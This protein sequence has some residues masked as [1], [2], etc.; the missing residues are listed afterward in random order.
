VRE[1]LGPGLGS[2]RETGEWRKS[3]LSRSIEAASQKTA[4]EWDRRLAATAMALTEHPGRRLAAAE[5]ALHRIAQFCEDQHQAHARNVEPQS[6]QVDRAHELLQNA[7]EACLA[8]TSSFSLFGGK[9]KRQLRVFLDHLAAYARQCLAQ[10]VAVAVRQFYMALCSRLGDRIKDLSFCRQR[11]RHLQDVLDMPMM[12]ADNLTDTPYPVDLSPTPS[13]LPSPESFWEAIRESA[14]TRVV[15]PNGDADLEQAAHRFLASLKPEHWVQLDQNLQDTV[16]AP[17][18]GLH[19]ACMGPADAVR[20]LLAPLVDRTALCLGSHLPITDVAE[21]D[22]TGGNLADYTLAYFES[23]APLVSGEE[24]G[25]VNDYLLTP[26]SDAGK[27]YGEAAR[28]LRP[29][30][31]V[32]RVPGQ[33]DLMFCREQGYLAVEDVERV[34]KACRKA[35]DEAAVVPQV[36]PHARFDVTDWVPLTP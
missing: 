5:A 16:L 9:A 17:L 29:G 14:T 27:A 36:S 22:A 11:L 12:A 8:G 33:A 19:R 24:T 28:K 34:F 6:Q 21:A 1:W 18:G 35:Y 15:L 20:H 7:L 10:D 26:A 30:V 13:S 3:R 23:A 2:N 32:L 4:E 31:Q 25:N